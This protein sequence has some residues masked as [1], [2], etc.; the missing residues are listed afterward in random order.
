MLYSFYA[1][2]PGQILR[3]DV[4]YTPIWQRDVYGRVFVTG[5]RPV[6]TLTVSR[7]PWVAP[8]QTQV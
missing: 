1:G 2:Q 7:G 4:S 8:Y 6:H 5:Y 3:D